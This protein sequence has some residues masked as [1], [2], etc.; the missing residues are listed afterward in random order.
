MTTCNM[1]CCKSAPCISL[2]VFSDENELQIKE[3]TTATLRCFP[4]EDAQSGTCFFTGKDAK[5]RAIFARSY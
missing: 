2:C 3:E 5:E 4:F 1:H